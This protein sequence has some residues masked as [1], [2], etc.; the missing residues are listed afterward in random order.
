M[1]DALKCPDP[2][3]FPAITD[4]KRFGE[5]LRAGDAYAATPVV[6]AA[7]KLA[8]MLLLRPGELR[9]GEWVEIDLDAALW[10]VP[11][12]RVKRELREKLQGTPHLV[13]L[14]K[15]ALAVLRGPQ[16]LTGCASCSW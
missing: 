13:P 3:N 4:P 5:L 10:G 16:P 6:R 9:F 15:Q 1:K 8:P 7:L 11:A 2:R 12:V 14:P